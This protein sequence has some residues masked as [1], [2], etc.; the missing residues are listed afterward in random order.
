MPSAPSP[1]RC[2]PPTS[3]APCTAAM[4]WPTPFRTPSSGGTA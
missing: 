3:P 4:L 2:R 1:S